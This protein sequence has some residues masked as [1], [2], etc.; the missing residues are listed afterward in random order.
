MSEEER[1]AQAVEAERARIIK[2]L[3]EK[4]HYWAQGSDRAFEL[5]HEKG[6][7]NKSTF[8]WELNPVLMGSAI[9]RDYAANATRDA[10]KVVK[11]E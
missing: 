1:I 9:G 10:I 2:A 11:G 4:Y 5:A 6:E 8:D 7:R 3:E